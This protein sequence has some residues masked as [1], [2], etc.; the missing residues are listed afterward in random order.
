MKWMVGLCFVLEALVL[1]SLS[2]SHRT[3]RP[4]L[5]LGGELCWKEEL[6]LLLPLH[7]VSLPPHDLCLR[8]QHRLCGPQWVYRAVSVGGRVG[9]GRRLEDSLGEWF[10]ILGGLSHCKGTLGPVRSEHHC[11]LLSR[12]PNLRIYWACWPSQW[13][14]A[15]DQDHN[16]WFVPRVPGMSQVIS[17]VGDVFLVYVS[18][19]LPHKTCL[20]SGGRRGYTR[21]MFFSGSW[22]ASED[23]KHTCARLHI[24]TSP[25]IQKPKNRQDVELKEWSSSG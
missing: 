18:S 1:D 24:H 2:L 16:Y 4:S 22:S 15:G 6:P 25:H 14:S 17:K 21:E 3:L 20:V 8:L 7:P 5:P 11:L 12:A 10:H 9:G 19:L 13:P 23:R